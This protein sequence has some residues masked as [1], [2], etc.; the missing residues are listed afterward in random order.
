MYWRR[1]PFHFF[2]LKWGATLVPILVINI[3]K[4]KDNCG[5][6]S[7]DRKSLDS[8]TSLSKIDIEELL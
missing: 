7:R 2:I 6:S 4:K 5:G 3:L 1:A 8:N